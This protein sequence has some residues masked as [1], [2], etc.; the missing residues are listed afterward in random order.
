MGKYR[1]PNKSTREGENIMERTLKTNER[2]Y[3]NLMAIAR[4]LEA[5]SENNT[6]Y[7]VRDV[8]LDL[9]QNWMWTTICRKTGNTCQILNPRQWKDIVMSTTAQEL[10][11]C[12]DDIRNGDYFREV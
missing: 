1:K 3:K 9:G 7:E 8:Y 4:M 2:E 11:V 12:V 10:A 5:L 6:E